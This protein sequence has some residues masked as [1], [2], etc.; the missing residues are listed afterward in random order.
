MYQPSQVSK[1][2]KCGKVTAEPKEVMIKN[3]KWLSGMVMAQFNVFLSYSESDLAL[4][5]RIKNILNR[6][7]ISVYSYTHYPEYG[8]YIPEIIKKNIRDSEYFVV[9]LT[10]AGIESQWVNQEIG[11]AFE[12]NML[13]IPIIQ[14]E[15]KSKGFVELRQ[16]INYSPHNPEDAIRDLIYRLRYLCNS[17]SIQLKCTNKNCRQ[18]F[19]VAIPNEMEISEAIEN[20]EVFFGT[21]TFCKN[22]VHF[23]PKTFE[24]VKKPL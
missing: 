3:Y 14:I 7:Q 16:H 22:Q 20:N 13:I 19:V 2:E 8:E 9:L 12:L 6:I 10:Q 23:S 11:M 18:H 24:Q 17:T 5:E 15:V 1:C 4:I 21:C